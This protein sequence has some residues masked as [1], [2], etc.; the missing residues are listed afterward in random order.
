MVLDVIMSPKAVKDL[1]QRSV[2]GGD[3]YDFEKTRNEKEIYK[4]IIAKEKES[5]AAIKKEWLEKEALVQKWENEDKAL[6]KKIIAGT[7]CRKLQHMMAMRF[8]I[9]NKTKNLQFDVQQ[10]AILKFFADT[11]KVPVGCYLLICTCFY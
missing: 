11:L 8:C 10:S 4:G 2:K 9:S 1:A 3:P 7:T 6:Q 5:A